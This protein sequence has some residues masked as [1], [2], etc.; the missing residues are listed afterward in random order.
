MTADLDST[1]RVRCPDL[2]CAAPQMLV[3]SPIALLVALWG[4]SGVRALEQ[5]A[6]AQVARKCAAHRFNAL[7]THRAGT[8]ERYEQGKRDLHR[9]Q[10]QLG[11]KAARV[12]VHLRCSEYADSSNKM[13][14][15]C[16]CGKNIKN[17]RDFH[18][19]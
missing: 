2:T 11:L 13:A 4:M 17:F 7:L 1:Y 18:H 5:M 6:A 12:M 16:I 9:G 19:L 10:S 3:A 15:V 14:T 8:L